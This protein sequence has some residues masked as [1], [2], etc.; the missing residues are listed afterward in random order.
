M[1]KPHTLDELRENI[2]CEIQKVTP[3]VLAAT[4]RNM[5]HRDQLCIDAQGGHFQHHLNRISYRRTFPAPPVTTTFHTGMTC[6]CKPTFSG[7]TFEWNAL[8]KVK[9]Y[10]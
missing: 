8:Y 10:A 4:F 9:P 2:R 6:K 7:A 5:Q 3:E 1:N